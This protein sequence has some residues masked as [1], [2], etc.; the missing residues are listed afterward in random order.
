M[1]GF[2]KEAE[3][4]LCKPKP[5][6]CHTDVMGYHV[7][8]DIPNYWAFAKNFVLQDHRFEAAGS[9]SLPD[10]LYE[11]PAGRPPAPRPATR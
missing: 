2:I 8:S 10:Q 3:V 6:P 7:E 11:S 5:A 1:N 4:K 9:W